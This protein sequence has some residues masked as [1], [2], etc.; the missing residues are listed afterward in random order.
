MMIDANLLVI[1]I[2]L[3]TAALLLLLVRRMRRTDRPVGLRPL[4]AFEALEKQVGR[5]V[6][7]GRHL[8]VTLGRAGLD[9]P[10][11]P[12]SV[13]A[14]QI[15]DH[16]AEESC[17]SGTPPEVTVGEGTLLPAAQ[18]SLRRAYEAAGR[19]AEYH[20]TAVTFIADQPFRFTYAAGVGDAIAHGDTA[21]TIAVGRFGS[22]IAFIA[23]ASG[24]AEVDQIVGVDDPVAMAVA[25]A[26][27]EDVLWGEEL[28]A[29]GAYLRG[30]VA[31]IA[32]LRAQ[33]ILR[34]LIIATIL[35]VAVLRLLGA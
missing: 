23:E 30:G 9:G 35:I 14:L 25:T 12:T 28:F 19:G 34:W 4:R 7:S 20:P 18:D 32:S 29:A 17:E 15:L 3:F 5:A 26:N 6:E 27:T 8:H 31:Q 16:L 10:A 21:S 33:D 2:L 11:G 13:A 1:G 22:E 24:R